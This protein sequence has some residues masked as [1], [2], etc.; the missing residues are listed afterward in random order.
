[1]DRAAGTTIAGAA[2][3]PRLGA[4]G[5][6]YVFCNSGTDFPPII[7]GLAEAAAAGHALPEAITVPHEHAALGMAHGYWQATGRGQAV[8]LHTNV[9]LANGAIGA[10]NAAC[11]LVPLLI[12]GGR[13]PVTEEG[14]FGARTVPIG[15]GQEMRDQHALVREATKWD[16]ELRLPE[17]VVPLLDRAHAIANSTPAG[18][19]YLSLPREALCGEIASLALAAPPAI[20]PARS[21]PRAADIG[22]LAD[23]IAAAERPFL[24]AQRGA[25]G[26][27]GFAALARIAEAWAVPV[28]HWWATAIAVP[29]D[30]PM[31]VGADPLPFLAEA[32]LVL[33]LDSLA[34]WSPDLHRP[35]PD[36]RIVHLGPDP[37]HARTPVRGFRSD[38]SLAG[39]TEEIVLAL[40]AALDRLGPPGAAADRRRPGIAARA[41]VRRAEASAAARAGNRAPMTKAWVSLCLSEAIAGADRPAT[42]ISE[43][44]CPL[45]PLTLR[46]HGA[47]RQEP[48]S[49]GLGYGLPAALGHQLADPAALVF[50]T[51]GDGSYMFANPVAC[52]QIAEARGLPV[53]TLVLNNGEW[54]AVRQSVAGLYPGGQAAR[55]NAMPLTRLDPSPDFAAIAA[56]SR[57]HAERVEDGAALPEA[58][59]RAIAVATGERRQ[60]LLD[61]RIARA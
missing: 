35:A 30:H 41:A 33:V 61:L 58:L 10:I 44:G 2:I 18:P 60:V 11:D 40:A 3:F 1:M 53:I 59:A 39:E 32:D 56:A 52:H 27:A 42:V 13:T 5:V 28:C 26:P 36:A 54:G 51:M 45:A 29:T 55:A 16:Y 23:W 4:L 37:L 9:G 57:A 34:P 15:W 17:Q 12:L 6:E 14:R 38:L 50:A 31:E 49:G 21:A 47:W 24:V 8:I 46:R 20:A 43:L 48:H 25:G 7:E 19:V 22:K